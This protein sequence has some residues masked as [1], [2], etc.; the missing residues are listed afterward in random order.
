MATTTPFAYNTGSPNK[1]FTSFSFGTSSY[2]MGFGAATGG[3]ND[4]HEL[5][6][7]VLQ[8]T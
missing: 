1:T 8:F 6:S 2:Y 4:N 3:A 7:W 5:L